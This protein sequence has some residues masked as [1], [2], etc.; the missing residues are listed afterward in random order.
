V[1]LL[2]YLSRTNA[3]RLR[4]Y[5]LGV[6]VAAA[7]LSFALSLVLVRR[8]PVLAFYTIP[9]RVWEFAIGVLT[10]LWVY[11]ARD[12]RSQTATFLGLLSAI[13]L[14][15]ATML[16]DQRFPH[17]GYV[18][19]IPTAATAGLLV[20]GAIGP[21]SVVPAFLS[22]RLMRVIGR[23]SYS[24]YLWHWPMLV[25]AVSRFPHLPVAARFTIACSAL[26]PAA[27]TYVYFE[28]PIRYSAY[29][30]Q[31]AKASLAGALVTSAAVLVI[32]VTQVR[33]AEARLGREPFA[34]IERA[35]AAQPKVYTDGCPGIRPEEAITRCVYGDRTSA[36]TVVLLGDSHAAQWFPALQQ[37]A[38]DRGW[39]LV[40]L[41][42]R[43]CPPFEFTPAWQQPE[44][45]LDRE[46]VKWRRSAEARLSSAK[47]ALVLV[48]SRSSPTIW[49]G[50]SQVSVTSD[51]TA[52]GVYERAL[53]NT[54]STSA[55]TGARLVVL[56]DTPWPGFDIPDCL[57]MHL[58]SPSSCRIARPSSA[59][60]VSSIDK[61]AA[62]RIPSAVYVDLT[63]QMCDNVYCPAV[64]DGVIRYR[65][66]SHISVAF[67]LSLSSVLDRALISVLPQASVH[68]SSTHD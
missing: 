33:F 12:T 31:R 14:C 15:V 52:R 67:A 35:R 58:N 53:W 41:T 11:R 6:G 56:R 39:R 50:G 8:S 38:I 17:P 13:S 2:A 61:E 45:A 64:R 19:L 25:I 42:R 26:V 18:T 62:L 32:A 34:S 68:H 24:W 27:L 46:C 44:T 20:A 30:R 10:M 3:S 65:D 7:I 40:S 57:E 9:T 21:A 48:S 16:I 36:I 60:G 23:L 5:F 29:L 54:Y 22:L 51:P 63:N 55:R 66:H 49:Q 28:N 37:I 4:R 1:L 59:E 47:P 43:G